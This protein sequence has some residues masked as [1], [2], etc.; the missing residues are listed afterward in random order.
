MRI[1]FVIPSMGMGGSETV[2]ANLL[3]HIDTSRFEAHLALLQASGQRLADVPAHVPVHELRVKH[4]R[5]AVVSLARLC[6][7]LN[8]HVVLSTSGHM[9]FAVVAARTFMPSRTRI[10]TRENAEIHAPEHKHS[11]V[12]LKAYQWAYRRAD[13]VICQSDHMKNELVGRFGI[14]PSKALRI[15]NPVDIDSIRR[16]SISA[17]NPLRGSGPHLVSV[18][19]L[20]YEKGYDFLLRAMSEVHAALPG[21][22]L[23][24]IGDGPDASLLRSMQTELGLQTCVHFTGLRRNPYSFVANANCFVLPSRTEALPNVVLESLALGTPVVA[25]NCTPSLFEIS[26]CTGRLHIVPETSGAAL[27][28]GILHCLRAAMV[29]SRTPPEASFAE[30]FDVHAV[31]RQYERVFQSG[32]HA[33]EHR[34]LGNVDRVCNEPADSICSH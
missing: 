4:A 34:S 24:L 9:N 6:R 21:A 10:Y 29:Q 18:G 1:L 23:T 17:A 26:A 25:A 8:P 7:K 31:V 20:S 32:V 11:C 2:F 30:R 27:A 12:R 15:Y 28:A 5:N 16:L 3:R 13:L 19:R 22:T 14:S 33:D